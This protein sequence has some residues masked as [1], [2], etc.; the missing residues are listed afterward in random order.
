MRVTEISFVNTL[1][2][3]YLSSYYF[4]ENTSAWGKVA[5]LH[6]KVEV[7]PSVGH[8]F[9]NNNSLLIAF[10]KTTLGVLSLSNFTWIHR[11]AVNLGT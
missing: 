4:S 7:T 3:K 2:L 1:E 8:A 6:H 10:L 9:D 11:K 5:Y